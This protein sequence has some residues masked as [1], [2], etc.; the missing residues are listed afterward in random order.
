MSRRPFDPPFAGLPQ[1]IPVFPL[2]GVL[3]LF[4]RLSF[5]GELTAMKACGELRQGAGR[6]MI[7]G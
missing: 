4:G 3:L 2:T 1:T 6:V 5:D 7:G